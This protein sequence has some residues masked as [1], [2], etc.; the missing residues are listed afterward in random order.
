M[1]ALAD[2]KVGDYVNDHY[3]AS[4]LKVGTF[5]IANGAKQ[6]GNV[7][8]YF[9]LPD[10]SVLHGIAGPVDAAQFLKEA[11][12]V[13]E[14]RKLAIFEAQGNPARYREF[15]RH[16]HAERLT[17]DHGVALFSRNARVQANL[18]RQ[19]PN[20]ELFPDAT[21]P[22]QFHRLQAVLQQQAGGRVQDN[23]AKVH[24]LMANYPLVKIEQVYRYV[25][26]RI[27]GEQISTAPVAQN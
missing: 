26:E 27:L 13:V 10:G 25:F 12:W 8:T 19:L 5:T 21:D 24:Q 20:G 3:V 18:M 1:N 11:R 14:T 7:A 17:K 16:A 15:I 2:A 22:M 4:F 23:Q 6:G 9:C